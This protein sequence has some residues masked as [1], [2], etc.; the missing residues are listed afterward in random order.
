M[1]TPEG[2]YK[3]S[4]MILLSRS[5]RFEVNSLL[6][7]FS[8]MITA[9]IIL[10]QDGF[11]KMIL[12]DSYGKVTWTENRKLYKGLSKITYQ[13]LESLSSGSYYILFDYNGMQVQK[14]MTKIN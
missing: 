11:V 3:Q 6:N 13:G 8:S 7:P 12:I 2:L 14:K 9:D 10:P 1:M 4:K 5:Y